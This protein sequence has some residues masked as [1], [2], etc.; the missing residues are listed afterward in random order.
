MEERRNR[1]TYCIEADREVMAPCLGLIK[2]SK[3][4][5]K[6]VSE[7]VKNHGKV[8]EQ[9]YIAQMDDPADCS[10]EISPSIDELVLCLY[11]PRNYIADQFNAAK[12]ASLLKK[13]L[14]RVGMSHM[15]PES[16]NSW[17]QFLNRAVDHNMDKVKEL[18]AA[19]A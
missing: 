8:S 11:P 19:S 12:V 18:T 17:V 10:S 15:C 2:A 4:C 6:E 1:D 16:E 3:A 13:T 7:A 14:D 9:E 5:L